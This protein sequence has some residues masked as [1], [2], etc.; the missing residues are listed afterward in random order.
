MSKLM[1]NI[2]GSDPKQASAKPNQSPKRDTNLG[3]RSRE[4]EDTPESKR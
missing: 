1:N 4:E 2:Y 3:K